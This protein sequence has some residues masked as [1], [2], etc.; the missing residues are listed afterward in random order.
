MKVK[1]PVS[2]KIFKIFRYVLISFLA[3]ICLYPFWYVVM[4]SLS[5]G[6]KLM[7]HTGLLL[8]PTGFSW[9]AYKLV[10]EEKALYTGFYNTFILLIVGVPVNVI[11]T[12]LGAYVMSRKN[13]FFKRPLTL[14]CMFTMYF[15]G[16][17]IP[18]YLTLKDLNLL[19]NRFAVVI[20]FAIST[21]NMIILRT[22]FEG[23]P[24]SLVDAARI[25][26]AGHLRT[27]FK[28]VLPLSK[29]TLAVIAMYYGM[30]TWNAWFW[31]STILRDE[32]K[33]PLQAV[34]RNM[35][36][37]DTAGGDTEILTLVTV[38]YSTIV[39]SLIPVLFVYPF[40]QKYFT[41]GV[42]IGGVKE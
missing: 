18:F 42:L 14:F 40:M 26:G 28:V 4:A 16:G 20:A 30:S 23:I 39:V 37:E 21:Y 33:L 11:M 2:V 27:L 38:K 13:V 9:D 6:I 17:T 7:G 24:D 31:S 19:G 36:I 5:D 41:K 1:E 10:L 25:D 35:I 22:A 32:S 3:L 12:A 8:V 15:S 34:L 29:A